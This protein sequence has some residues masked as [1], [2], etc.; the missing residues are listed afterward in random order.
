VLVL[1]V[2]AAV[3]AAAVA[4]L[5]ARVH[6]SSMSPALRDGDVLLV[7]R[8]G[9]HFQAPR[10]GDIVVTAQPS[11]GSIVKRV[12]AVPGDVVEIDPSKPAVMLQPG[13]RGPW[14]RLVEPYVGASWTLRESCC[15]ARGLTVG[16]GPQPL[17]VPAGHYF[18]LGDNRDVSTDS[19]RFGLFTA[20]QIAGRVLVRWW[21]FDRAGRVAGEPSLAAA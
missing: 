13:G 16:G 6:G 11:G 1:V 20:D 18:L 5:T 19:R 17:R 15:D 14:Q 12:I 10:R 21:P 7:D 9:V 2:I 4:A 3:G 8:V